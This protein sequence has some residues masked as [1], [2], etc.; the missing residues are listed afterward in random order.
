M[1]ENNLYKLILWPNSQCLMELDGFEEN[2]S[3]ADCEKF[4]SSA[5]FVSINW[6]LEH[7]LK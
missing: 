7:N 4:G 6:L 5:Y 3:L 1:G 2:S